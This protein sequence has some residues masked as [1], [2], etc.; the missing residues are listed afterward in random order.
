MSEHRHHGHRERMKLRITQGGLANFSDHEL[1]EVLLYYAI[2]QGDTNPIGHALIDRFGSFSGILKASIPELCEVKGIGESSAIMMRT[3]G[4]FIKRY[5]MSEVLDSRQVFSDLH[6]IHQFVRQLFLDESR[7]VTYLLCLDQ[8]YR[9]LHYQMI[10]K[11]TVNF[12]QINL[13]E[14][15]E[16]AFRY[17]TAIV[18]LAHNH[19]GGTATP[20]V[21]DR[22]TTREIA[23]ML[24]ALGIEL[25]DHVIV[26]DDQVTSMRK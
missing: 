18:V 14:I 6:S 9:L 24:R 20:S 8:S 4:E 17:Q 10:G 22:S 1:L 15:T 12:C 26:S 19:P 13:R 7:E 21:A 2:R 11:G 16:I 23:K 5:N 25:C 3:M